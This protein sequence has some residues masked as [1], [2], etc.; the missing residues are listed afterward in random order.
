MKYIL[1]ILKILFALAVALALRGLPARNRPEA[2][3]PA[4]AFFA[5]AVTG[6]VDTGSCDRNGK[7]TTYYDMKLVYPAGAYQ[8]FPEVAALVATGEGLNFSETL[9]KQPQLRKISP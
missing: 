6:Y 2:R 5:C 3:A 7:L 1:W 8:K 9:P 4:A